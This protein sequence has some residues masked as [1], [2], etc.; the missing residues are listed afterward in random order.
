MAEMFSGTSSDFA[1]SIQQTSDSG[2]IIAGS[3]FSNNGDVSGNHGGTDYWIVKL[4]STG[5]IQWSNCY[6][7]GWNGISQGYDG[8]HSIKQTLDGGYVV[9]GE[10]NSSNGDVSGIHGNSSD[11]WIVKLNPFGNLQ[12]QKCLGG[13][14]ID[15]ARAITLSNDSG[16]VIVGE[17]FSN[18]GDVSGNHDTTGNTSDYWVVK[19]NSIG[20]LQWQ[21]CYGGTKNDF[22]ESISTTT[23]GGYIISGITLSYDGDVTGR[24]D[25]INHYMDGWVI[26]IDSIGNL[27]WQKCLGGTSIDFC[28]SIA[29]TSDGG[30][31]VGGT[32][33]SNDFEAALNHGGA[34]AFIV[35]L[36]STGN[37]EWHS[38]YGNDNSNGQECVS[39][40]KTNDG[41]YAFVGDSYSDGGDVNGFNGY[42][43]IWLVKLSDVSFINV[44]IAT[45]G[46]CNGLA[47]AFPTAG[48]PPFTFQ[49]SGGQSTSSVNN[50]CNG[51]NTV[52]ITDSLGNISQGS[53]TVINSDLIV[54]IIQTGSS[55]STCPDDTVT[56]LSSNGI[57]V[58]SYSW[59]GFSDTT[60]SLTGLL[61]YGWIV[62]CVTDISGCVICDSIYTGVVGINEWK[63]LVEDLS[64]APN[65]L[66]QTSFINWSQKRNGKVSIQLLDITGREIFVLADGTFS[67]GKHSVSLTAGDASI[68]DGLYLIKIMA[69][70]FVAMKKLL[71]QRSD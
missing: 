59:Q 16:F 35:K 55:C 33:D 71:V 63:Q 17:V 2:Y 22:P 26:K 23:D 5:N 56:L 53:F 61:P 44:Q 3:T 48:I 21:R 66:T 19:I 10:S 41:K 47:T 9:A 70:E 7:G 64:I 32:T 24:H 34:D 52:V 8:P 51:V 50:L 49:W 31:L 18:D 67:Q 27:K 40:I 4:D 54:S 57:G 36:D 43:D 25:S 20:N 11:Y 68:S 42:Q 45:C 39:I 28:N 29:Q 6:G 37:I 1:R 12:W 58:Y 14:G 65:P 38:C 30:Y 13:Y 60:A 15:E 46:L 62:G 69:G